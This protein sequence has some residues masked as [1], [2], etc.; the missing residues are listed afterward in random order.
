MPDL[1]GN[2]GNGFP[3]ASAA[4]APPPFQPVAAQPYQPVGG[5]GYQATG[6]PGQ[7]APPPPSSGNSTLKIILIIVAVLVVIGLGVLSVIG[8]GVWRVSRAIHK[9]GDSSI[10]IDTPGGIVSTTP[11]QKF[12]T[13]ELGTDVYPGAETGKGGI[14]M[15]LPT[16]PMIAANYLTTDSKDKVIAFYKD[17]FGSKAQVMETGDGAIMTLKKSST[18]TVMLTINQ[19]PNRYDGKTQIHIMHTKKTP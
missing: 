13:E 11:T 3:P 2:S 17:K 1:P 16:G 5:A 8:Y 10:S 14:K 9:S 6:M 18:D 7:F 4:G 12:T 19:K 15:N